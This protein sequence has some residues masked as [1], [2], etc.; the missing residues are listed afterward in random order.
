MEAFYGFQPD[1]SLTRCDLLTA[2]IRIGA[3]AGD[4]PAEAKETLKTIAD[5]NRDDCLSTWHLRE[6]LEKLRGEL[7]TKLGKRL[8]VRN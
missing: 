4:D 7:E 1:S 8:H 3:S 6:W 2:S 5:Y